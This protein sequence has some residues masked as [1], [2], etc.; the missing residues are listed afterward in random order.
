LTGRRPLIANREFGPGL[1]KSRR[2]IAAGQWAECVPTIAAIGGRT[3]WA[4][5]PASSFAQ[6]A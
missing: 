3:A 6:Q 5:L 1:A 2:A 4:M